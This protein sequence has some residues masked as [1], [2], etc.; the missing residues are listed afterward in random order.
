MAFFVKKRIQVSS[1]SVFFD[2]P[3]FDQSLETLRSKHP[4]SSICLIIHLQ[5]H[6]LNLNRRTDH[7]DISF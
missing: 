4:S 2:R 5:I 1:L 6:L 7:F 3:T